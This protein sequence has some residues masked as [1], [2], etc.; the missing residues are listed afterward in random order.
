MRRKSHDAPW[1]VYAHYILR[2]G[3]YFCICY[4]CN[5]FCRTILCKCS[6]SHHA[7]SVCPSCT[8]ILSKWTNI[9]SK[10]FHHCVAKPF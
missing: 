3:V 9:S 4:H 8:W 10:F 7:V 6:L 5:Y 2:R 1:Q